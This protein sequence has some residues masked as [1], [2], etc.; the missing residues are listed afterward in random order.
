MRPFQKSKVQPPPSQTRGSLG[1]PES[2]KVQLPPA[3]RRVVW[4]LAEKS[5]VQHPPP[6]GAK[7]KVGYRKRAL[8]ASDDRPAPLVFHVLDSVG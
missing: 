1:L 6:H 3:F 5:K 8:R 4:T 2:P 7:L